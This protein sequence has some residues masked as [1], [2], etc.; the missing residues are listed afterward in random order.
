LRA[1]LSRLETNPGQEKVIM[2][3]LRE[4]EENREAIREEISRARADVA[5][6]V[7]G[8]LVGDAEM[9]GT[10]ASH[11]RLLAR[12]RVSFVEALKKITEALDETQRRQLAR[13]IEGGGWWRRAAGWGESDADM[14]L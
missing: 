14:W 1:L 5:R 9:E 6:V 11:D 4:L 12:L 3:A 2:A 13:M 7:A 8:G 10:F